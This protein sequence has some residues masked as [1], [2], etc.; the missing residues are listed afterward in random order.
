MS[1]EPMNPNR[2]S[3]ANGRFGASAK[4][5]HEHVRNKKK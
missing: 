5:K 4:G 3:I 2:T 1:R